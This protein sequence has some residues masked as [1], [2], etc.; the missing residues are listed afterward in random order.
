MDGGILGRV[1]DMLI[2]RGVNVF[3]SAIENIIRRF[4]QIVEYRIEVFTDRQMD[5]ISLVLELKK[6]YDDLEAQE[7][8]M[9]L[10]EQLRA[11][12]Q[13]RIS[14]QLVPPDTLPRFEMKAKRLIRIER[15]GA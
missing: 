3:P 4:G 7:V 9:K 15:P 5:E 12:L 13:I 11:D 1:D 6:D 2:V 14:C 8:L 10:R